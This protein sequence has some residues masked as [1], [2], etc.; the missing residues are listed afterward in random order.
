M[1]LDEGISQF[2]HQLKCHIPA[3]QCMAQSLSLN[4][5]WFMVTKIIKTFEQCLTDWEVCKFFSAKNEQ[6]MMQ[7]TKA[8]MLLHSFLHTP[9]C[10]NEYLVLPL[11]EE[12]E[13]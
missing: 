5:E 1:H 9:K 12:T 8:G 10:K 4:A 13:V 6:I 11:G 3:I 7:N 2:I